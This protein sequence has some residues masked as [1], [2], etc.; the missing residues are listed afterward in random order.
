MSTIDTDDTHV[1]LVTFE[2]EDEQAQRRLLDGLLEQVEGWVRTIPGFVS[3][4]FHLSVDGTRIFNYA[5]WRSRAAWETFAADGRRERMQAAAGIV[6]LV[7]RGSDGP[8][9]GYFFE[10]D[11][12]PW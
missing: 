7:T 9:G 2:V 3:A 10:E 6:W 8:T 5:Q 11:R 12:I 4:N 1:E